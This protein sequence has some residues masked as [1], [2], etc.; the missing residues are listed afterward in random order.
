[1]SGDTPS[2][3]VKKTVLAV[4]ALVFLGLWTAT[5]F[6]YESQ[7]LYYKFG[8]DKALL[9]WGKAS[10]MAVAGLMV[11]QVVL[12]SRFAWMDRLL[13]VKFLF[14]VHQ[15]IGIA[16]ALLVI[17]HPLLVLWAD[18]FTFFPLEVRYWP[19]FLGSFTLAA[20][21]ALVGASLARNRLG[22]PYKFWQVSHRVSAPLVIAM[23]LIHGGTVSG[24]FD[25]AVPLAGL[26]LLGGLAAALIVRRRL[27]R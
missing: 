6:V 27:K 5:P 12:M 22:I 2:S 18:G 8:V 4:A 1:M 17:L 25:H 3:A 24:T 21:L 26:C 20:A 9:H 7:S 14:R 16:V 19:E 15:F 13:G 23:A 11:F 10:G